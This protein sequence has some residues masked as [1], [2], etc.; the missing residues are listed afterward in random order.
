VHG[1]INADK[2]I[3]LAPGGPDTAAMVISRGVGDR[4]K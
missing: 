3:G 1:K 2:S 4:I